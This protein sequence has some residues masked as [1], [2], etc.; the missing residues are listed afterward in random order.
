MRCL[1]PEC[2][3]PQFKGNKDY[4]LKVYLEKKFESELDNYGLDV[5]KNRKRRTTVFNLATGS[6]LDDMMAKTMKM[7]QVSLIKRSI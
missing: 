7:E 4:D 1:C 6:D 2:G 3:R 5:R